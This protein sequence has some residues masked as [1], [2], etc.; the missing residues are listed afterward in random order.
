MSI[1]WMLIP[2]AVAVAWLVP[3]A[4]RYIPTRTNS[5]WMVWFV[6]SAAAVLVLTL[7]ADRQDADVWSWLGFGA[8]VVPL[9]ALF[10]IDVWTHRLPRQISLVAAVPVVVLLSIGGGPGGRLAVVATAIANVLITLLWRALTRGSLGMGD[11]MVAPLLGAIVGWFSPWALVTLWLVASVVGA[12]WSL[13]LI[14]S[15]RR[16]RRDHIAYGPFLIVGTLVA[17]LGSAF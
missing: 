8:T 12:V 4:P 2:I 13:V 15:K 14:I 6:V 10:V 1:G 5:L 17:V 11:V 16:A 9:G 3:L 7:S